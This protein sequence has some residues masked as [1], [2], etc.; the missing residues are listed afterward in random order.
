MNAL[1]CRILS[2]LAFVIAAGGSDIPRPGLDYTFKPVSGEAV[3]LS[4]YRGSVVV[5]QFF[6]PECAHCQRT[7]Q[8]LE[9]LYK[10]LGPRGLM[11]LGVAFKAQEK[12]L[13]FITRFQITFPIGVDDR[14]ST[15]RYIQWPIEKIVSTPV[16]VLI[17][18]RGTIREQHSGDE[19]FA[20]DE[21]AMKSSI[22]SLLNENQRTPPRTQ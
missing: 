15:C 22:E 17:D 18:R 21:Q 2:S 4:K 11:V 1:C 19:T 12:A 8:T 9:K 16:L 6:S 7:S 3:S 20:A 10:E 13:D 5:V 14:E